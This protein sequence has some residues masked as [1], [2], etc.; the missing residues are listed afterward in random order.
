MAATELDIEGTGAVI[1][2]I[3]EV[4]TPL[5][6]GLQKLVDDYRFTEILALLDAGEGRAPAAS[7]A[8]R[9]L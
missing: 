2:R 6:A 7:P 1:E 3:R 9:E 8:K 4:D 5:A